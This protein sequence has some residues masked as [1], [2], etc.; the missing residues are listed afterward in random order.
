MYHLFL[1]IKGE[2]RGGAKDY[3]GSSESLENAK[4]LRQ[5]L[6]DQLQGNDY[7]TQIVF[8]NQTGFLEIEE[9]GS[10]HRGHLTEVPAVA[11]T[12]LTSHVA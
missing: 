2:P 5:C 1:W 4:A 6:F 8:V 9:A 10:F 12:T 7:E 11:P 3:Y